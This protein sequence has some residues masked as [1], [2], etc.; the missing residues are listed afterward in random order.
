MDIG[1]II[2]SVKKTHRLIVMEEAF[3]VASVST[4]V[5]Y[6]VQRNAF[7]YLDAPVRRL[8]QSDTPFAF[9]KP[10]IAEALPQIGDVVRTAKE[11]LYV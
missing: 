8:T 9:A 4:E 10:L 7:D 11:L 3:P 5:A 6:R 1:T 2:Q